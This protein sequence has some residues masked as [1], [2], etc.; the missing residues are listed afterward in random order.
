VRT[1]QKA[2]PT[3]HV[4]EVRFVRLFFKMINIKNVLY[5]VMVNNYCYKDM[6]NAKMNIEK[7][8]HYTWIRVVGE[9]DFLCHII[10][11]P[12]RDV[13]KFPFINVN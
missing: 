13:R 9:M 1:K 11:T 3:V 8:R 10:F 5:T 2:H 6:S 7:L 12:P 4:N